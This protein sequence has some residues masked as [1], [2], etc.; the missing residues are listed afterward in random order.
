MRIP[1]PAS[2]LLLSIG[3]TVAE[4]ASADATRGA[5][6]EIAKCAAIADSSERLRCFDAAV[7]GVKNALSTPAQPAQESAGS[8]NGFGL[9]KPDKP[10]L[11]AEDF[12]KPAPAAQPG[13]ITEISATVVEFARTLR[14]KALFI[15]DNGQV[16]RQTDGDSTVLRDPAAGAPMKVTIATGAFTSYNL[17]IEGRNGLI[18]VVR[19]K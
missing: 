19:V 10:V 1:V 16:W 11:K 18:K 2:L 14:G 9:P 8:L 3:L 6:V 12:G 7:P 4:L 5:L 13:E 15:L 17:T